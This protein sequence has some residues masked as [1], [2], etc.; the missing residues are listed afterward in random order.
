M[1]TNE[2]MQKVNCTQAR[3]R[4]K[5]IAKDNNRTQ[6]NSTQRAVIHVKIVEERRA[7]GESE[8]KHETDLNKLT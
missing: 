8:R 2:E 3:E 6:N 5:K 4:E 7:E 1:P